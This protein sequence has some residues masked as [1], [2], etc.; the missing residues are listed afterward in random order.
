M[1]GLK[2]SGVIL[3]VAC[4][5]D[6]MFAPPK[7]EENGPPEDAGPIVARTRGAPLPT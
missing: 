1:S 3:P 2:E 7:V 5:I 6:S 4:V